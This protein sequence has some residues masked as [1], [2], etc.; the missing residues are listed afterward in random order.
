METRLTNRLFLLLIFLFTVNIC[1]AK[2][3]EP[4]T[5]VGLNNSIPFSF[6]LPDGTPTG[7][8][9]EYW[10]LWSRVNDIPIK[11][12]MRN[13]HDG[14]EAIKNKNVML[15]MLFKSGS[16]VDIFDYSLPFHSI[17][18]G[19]V[20][21]K[22]YSENIN[23]KNKKGFKVAVQRAS[24]QA[25]YLTKNYPLLDLVYVDYMEEGIEL[26]LNEEVDALVGE[27]PH[28][29]AQ[30]GLMGLKGVFT[31]SEEILL[32]NTLHA[33][34]SKGQP[35]LLATINKGI[36]N[37]PVH[38]IIALE[39][40]WLP[41]IKPYYENKVSFASLTLAEKKWLQNHPDISIGIDPDFPP[42]EFIDESGSYT[43]LAADYIN[44]ANTLL[45]INMLPRTGL[46]WLEAF[47]EFKNGNIDI[48]SGAIITEERRKIMNFTDSYIDMPTAIIIRRNSIYVEN[49]TSLNNKILGLVEGDFVKLLKHD[50][51]DVIIQ[52]VESEVVGLERLQAG[53]I[54]AF[55][56]PIATANYELEKRNFDQLIIAAF[57][58][59][60]LKLA[61]AIRMGLEPLVPILNKTLAHMTDKERLSLTNSWLQSYISTGIDRQQLLNWVIPIILL[62]MMLI[63]TIITITNRRL[64]HVI[65]KNKSLVR[66]I[67]KIQEEERKIL[68]RDL[69]DEIGQ[70]LTALQLHINTAKQY[71]ASS[72][73]ASVIKSID[74]I[75]AV[76]YRS[77][78]ELM[79][80]LRPMVLD[81]YGLKHALSNHIFIKMLKESNIN[82]SKKIDNNLD[83][84]IGDELASSIYRLVQECI[85]NAAK[86]SKADN[87]WLSI[88]LLNDEIIMEIKDDGIG[89]DVNNI[90]QGIISGYG[91]KG[92]QDRVDA[93]DGF[94][95][96]TSDSTGTVHFFK[97][98]LQNS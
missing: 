81:E 68:S 10:K 30:F 64:S 88:T 36:D 22:E 4:I 93:M 91:L 25:S 29:N 11:I 84:I 12:V 86:Y 65:K 47:D 70:N 39:K 73:L 66:R 90:D 54:D 7:L 43:G 27:I 34:I 9:I 21:S 19:I 28:I 51:P 72:K 1:A 42:F 16:R 3:Q 18:T 97:F 83:N 92:I 20:Y 85:S 26:I 46:T 2:D 37:I 8:Y 57:A 48:M 52:T 61:I 14:I 94:H 62:I 13:L 40:K 5:V 71:Q 96:L 38:S 15:S 87:L 41:A 6:T 79:H 45:G 75:I 58:P 60:N 80:W 33:A 50:Y 76:T 49:M 31:I 77:S 67:V 17:Q 78:Y 56:A 98:A 35:E 59:Y 24:F 44:Y 53:E 23:L 55:I 82:Y 69:H 95:Q 89:F 63:I 32:T 74:E